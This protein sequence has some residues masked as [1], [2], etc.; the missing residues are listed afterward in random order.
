MVRR[1][2]LVLGVLAVSLLINLFIAGFVL[3][4]WVFWEPEPWLGRIFAIAAVGHPPPAIR[5][6]MDA[7]LRADDSSI[8]SAIDAVRQARREVRMAMR[9][10]PF[11]AAA[12][13]KAYADLRARSTDLQTM[14]H[15]A[16]ARA[17]AASPAEERAK[18]EIRR[19]DDK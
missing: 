14:I 2:S 16:T 1:S 4:R 3:T 7:E 13:D 15:G 11:D 18:I 5:E 17:I 8:R 9:A 6:K 10:E 19:R 12:L